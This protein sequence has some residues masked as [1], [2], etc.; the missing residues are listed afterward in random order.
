M[1]ARS[2]EFIPPHPSR[3]PLKSY[4][5][6]VSSASFQQS[7]SHR[8]IEQIFVQHCVSRLLTII[9]F[10]GRKGAATSSDRSPVPTRCNNLNEMWSSSYICYRPS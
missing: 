9:T 3:A 4:L 6:T 8:R 1:D 2:T 5:S 10:K 7:N